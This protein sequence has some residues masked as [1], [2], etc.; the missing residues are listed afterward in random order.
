LL[1]CFSYLFNTLYNLKILGEPRYPSL[2]G[3][4]EYK[5]RR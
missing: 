5:E 2:N 1:S 3:I 4:F